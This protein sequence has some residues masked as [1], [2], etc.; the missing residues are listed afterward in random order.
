MFIFVI[1]VIVIIAVSPRASLIAIIVLFYI[2]T[3]IGV[4]TTAAG[5]T[6]GG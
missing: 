5:C 4:K 1:L 2:W 3:I 6:K